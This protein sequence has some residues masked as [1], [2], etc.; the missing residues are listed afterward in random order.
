M[1]KRPRKLI[2]LVG[3]GN[4][5]DPT[6]QAAY[7]VGRLL[8]ERGCSIING[9]LGGVMEASARG[10]QEGAGSLPA[11]KRGIA[12]GISP[13]ATAEGVNEFLDYVIP[14]G[15]GE[16]RNILIV[17]ASAV[18]IAIGGEFGTLTEV[19]FGLK[20]GVPVISL[21][22]WEVHPSVTRAATQS[23]A[24]ELALRHLSS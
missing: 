21:G 22:S 14:S 24:V 7:E 9:A 6:T 15:F 3:A 4:P 11:D 23:D 8:G 19:G 18:L 16:A 1:N 12:I 10:F 13:N 20:R 5:D 2:G 17:N